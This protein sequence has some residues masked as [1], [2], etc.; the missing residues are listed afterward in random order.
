M[1]AS[2]STNNSSTFPVTGWF[3]SLSSA[4][5]RVTF[6]AVPIRETCIRPAKY[7]QNAILY[8][9]Q[10]HPTPRSTGSSSKRW[11]SRDPRCLAWQM[12]FV[13]RGIPFE[14]VQV[15]DDYTALD[16]HGEGFANVPMILDVDG[17]VVGQK[18]LRK[19]A[20]T[21]QPFSEECVEKAKGAEARI[22]NSVIQGPLMAGV[23]LELILLPDNSS[24]AK[25]DIP[26]LARKLQSQL[27][28]Q[29]KA[30]IA[31]QIHALRHSSPT[32]QMPGWVTTMHGLLNTSGG[33]GSTGT[34]SDEAEDDTDQGLS[35]AALGFDIDQL[36]QE[37]I[38]TEACEAIDIL[39]TLYPIGNTQGSEEEAGSSWI[40]GTSSPSQLDAAFFALLHTIMSLP[41]QSSH[42]QGSATLRS[43]VEKYPHLV[44][45][46]RRIWTE[47]VKPLGG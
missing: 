8:V 13:F 44:A 22:L 14:C 27:S 9:D 20:D 12:Q 11:A 17:T 30:K 26:F 18:H 1:A 39:A 16:Y 31:A 33:I 40:C 6:D 23:L 10:G 4:F 19:W 38:R 35:I 41:V 45:Y 46:I 34:A 29:K 7:R 47:Y 36:D 25:S 2:T 42:K 5:P 37:S 32:S 21:V 3:K 24:S 15:H 28:V 43:T